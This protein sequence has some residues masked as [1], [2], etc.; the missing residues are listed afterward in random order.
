M[1]ASVTPSV[2]PPLIMLPENNED[3]LKRLDCYFV[4]SSCINP[5]FLMP[6]YKSCQISSG[7]SRFLV[8]DARLPRTKPDWIRAYLGDLYNDS[9]KEVYIVKYI[10]Q[11]KYILEPYNEPVPFSACRMDIRS[12]DQLTNGEIHI[13][14]K[15]NIKEQAEKLALKRMILPPINGYLLHSQVVCDL[16]HFDFL[17]FR[18]EEV[19][20][21]FKSSSIRSNK[22]NVRAHICIICLNCI[23]ELIT[24]MWVGDKGK[25]L[26]YLDAEQEEY[27]PQAQSVISEIIFDFVSSSFKIDGFSTNYFKSKYSFYIEPKRF[28][29]EEQSTSQLISIRRASTTPNR[30][31]QLNGL[32]IFAYCRYQSSQK[33]IIPLACIVCIIIAIV[34]KKKGASARRKFRPKRN[35]KKNGYKNLNG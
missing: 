11:C 10:N 24:E 12:L 14:A 32:G 34:K 26:D 5:S 16:C 13:Y 7:R 4:P 18:S 29:Q 15:S 28:R 9:F 22:R 3:L 31:L 19:Y 33:M 35:L 21:A 23:S 2:V 20:S 6:E 17:P 1:Q 30:P 25:I 8:S 27:V